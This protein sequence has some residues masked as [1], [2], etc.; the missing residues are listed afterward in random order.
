MNRQ[1]DDEKKH[2]TMDF[3]CSKDEI[4]YETESPPEERQSDLHKQAV[5]TLT[6][7]LEIFNDGGVEI[8]DLAEVQA[9][10]ILKII[11][12]EKNRLINIVRDTGNDNPVCFKIIKALVEG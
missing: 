2:R 6:Q 10:E 3:V 4:K 11:E 12:A 8:S 9:G 1:R 5:E 7:T